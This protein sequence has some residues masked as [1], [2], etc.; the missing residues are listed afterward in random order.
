MLSRR[1][2][3]MS[4]CR[5][6]WQCATLAILL[7]QLSFA[8]ARN[9]PD[10]PAARFT[11]LKADYDGDLKA[12][13]KPIIDAKTGQ[14]ERFVYMGQVSPDKYMP[15]LLELGHSTDEVTAASALAL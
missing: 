8:S 9:P 7:L 4:P 5:S 1:S 13:T 6:W 14:V 3:R 2:L 11:K 10:T 12:V 15:L